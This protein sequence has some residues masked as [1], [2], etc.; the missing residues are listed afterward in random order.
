MR[1]NS[2]ALRICPRFS[3]RKILF[4]RWPRIAE[5]DGAPACANRASSAASD[6][7]SR[8]CSIST[9]SGCRSTK[10][11]KSRCRG[12]GPEL[13]RNNR[14]V[15]FWRQG[16]DGRD[17]LKARSHKR[18]QA[19]ELQLLTGGRIPSHTNGSPV[20][21]DR[22]MGRRGNEALEVDADVTG[23]RPRF[24]IARAAACNPLNAPQRIIPHTLTWAAVLTSSSA[25]GLGIRRSQPRLLKNRML[26]ICWPVLSCRRSL[27]DLRP[28]PHATGRSQPC[29]GPELSLVHW[30]A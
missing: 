7:P 21:S 8:S 28:R 24:A 9:T 16:K 14:G 19:R 5:S 30:S 6:G 22:P 2:S 25:P 26:T 29:H 3:I 18:P 13:I 4:T 12:F 11:A 20:N 10:P 17:V 15:M 27:M 23:S 1:R